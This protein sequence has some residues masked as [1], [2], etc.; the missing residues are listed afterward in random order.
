MASDRD[1]EIS[2]LK[3]QVEDTQLQLEHARKSW[4]EEREKVMVSITTQTLI[5]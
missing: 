4:R 1:K 2:D 3:R 5:R